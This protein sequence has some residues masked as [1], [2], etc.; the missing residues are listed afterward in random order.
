T[1]YVI[2]PTIYVDDVAVVETDSGTT[3]LVFEVTLTHPLLEEI[4]VDYA[5]ADGTA[6][7]NDYQATS[8]T[9]TFAAG[10]T[11]Q[12]ITVTVTDDSNNEPHETFVVNLSNP[13]NATLGDAQATGIIFDNDAAFVVNSTEDAVD[14]N[15]GDGLAEDNQGRTTLRAAIMEANAVAGNDTIFVPAGTYTLTIGGN[16]EDNAATGD[17]DITDSSGKLRIT[18]AGADLVTIDANDLDRVIDIHAGANVKIAFLE[19]SGGQ[20]PGGLS[21]AGIQITD[22]ETSL[23]N[24]DILG[25]VSGRNGGGILIDGTSVVTITRSN[26]SDNTSDYRGGGIHVF[27]EQP[28]GSDS[29]LTI[30]HTQISSN[31]A[32]SSGG[33]IDNRAGDLSILSSRI[34]SNT[35]SAGGGITNYDRLELL[36][37]EISNNTAIN[38]TGGGINAASAYRDFT[39]RSLVISNSSFTGNSSKL[40]GGG[41]NVVRQPATITS[42]TF[43][44]N[45]STTDDGGGLSFL[46]STEYNWDAILHNNTIT[47]NSAKLNGGGVYNGG[48]DISVR[49][50]IIAGNS[51]DGQDNDVSGT[52]DSDGY[53][54]IGDKGNTGGFT[55][56]ENRDQVGTSESP[57]DPLLEPLADN[58]GPTLTHRPRILSP[59]ID[60]GDHLLPDRTDQRGVS[61]ISNAGGVDTFFNDDPPYE[62]T[63]AT[64][65]DGPFSVFAA[66]VDGD[67]DIDV[68]SASL[69]DDKIAWYENDGS[70]AFTP[71]TI[72]T[73]ADGASSVF[74]ADVDG[75]G[76]M[77]VLSASRFDDKIAW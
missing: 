6:D 47:N 22:A 64:T 66:D 51:A 68:L 38:S 24:V 46:G 44:G 10:V 27:G 42:N 26:I 76:D 53:N 69:W 67:G 52:Y 59:I 77:D 48:F 32:A 3:D 54:L 1:D 71:R 17:L 33:G 41:L 74:A 61:G 62:H 36:H 14:A 75:D 63:I 49:N 35:A 28:N 57:I 55:D 72:T 13:G 12:T 21:G 31:T 34:T 65:A 8:G 40:S 25:N 18:G 4:T 30:S 73:M 50:T 16:N 20:T 9:L 5:T 56:N 45:S 70:E 29:V 43:S 23:S 58:G 7:G 11:S 19:L 15:P 60:A 39:E 37:S 2:D